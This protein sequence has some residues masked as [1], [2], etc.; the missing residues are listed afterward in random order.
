MVTMRRKTTPLWTCDVLGH[1]ARAQIGLP[2]RVAVEKEENPAE[3]K[4]WRRSMVQCAAQSFTYTNLNNSWSRKS[5][6][7]IEKTSPSWKRGLHKQPSEEKFCSTLHFIAVTLKSRVLSVASISFT[8]T[9]SQLWRGC[10][11]RIPENIYTWR[12]GSAA[13]A[14][15]SP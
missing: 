15:Y 8:S 12:R 14:S 2:F 3:Q 11:S 13:A 1:E 7:R 5:G 10:E 6:H 4:S 9:D